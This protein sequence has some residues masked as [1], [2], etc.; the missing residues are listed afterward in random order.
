MP[1]KFAYDIAE[2]LEMKDRRILSELDKNCRQSHSQIAKKVGLSK[3]LT[4]YRI[5]NLVKNEVIG[6]FLTIF[7]FRRFGYDVYYVLVELQNVNKEKEKAIMDFLGQQK[8]ISWAIGLYGKWNIMF[9][10][11]SRS[12]KDFNETMRKVLHKFDDVIKEWDLLVSTESKISPKNYLID[13]KKLF[14]E[15]PHL[16]SEKIF[17]PDKTDLKIM[18]S[19]YLNPQESI[20]QIV[21]DTKLPYDTIRSRMKKFSDEKLVLRF[22]LELNPKVVQYEFHLL[23]IEF[24]HKHLDKEKVL[25]EF[26]E[27]HPNVTFINE[28]IGKKQL[29]VDFHVKNQEHLYEI[30]SKLKEKYGEIIKGYEN[31][32]VS[33]IHKCCFL[34]GNLFE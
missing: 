28:T 31:V 12:M 33:Q 16:I 11:L 2:Q 20:V 29:M 27:R 15:N 8:P 23:F 32:R 19:L 26:L 30:I 5:N 13:S 17:V 9:A 3:Q 21:E 25:K 4:S 18:N 10:L 22:N 6:R 24:N 34:P 14:E 1:K 7:N